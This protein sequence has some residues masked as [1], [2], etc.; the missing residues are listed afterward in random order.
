MIRDFSIKYIHFYHIPIRNEYQLI[1]RIDYSVDFPV[2]S[3]GKASAY[4]VEDPGLIPGLERSPGEG[5]GN[6]LQYSCLENPINWGAWCAALHGV[7]KSLTGLSD[8]TFT[9]IHFHFLS[10][11]LFGYS[12]LN[13]FDVKAMAPHSSTLA[14]QIPWT[15]GPGGL[16]FMG[17]LGVGHDW[18]TSLYFF[19]FMHWRRKWHPLQCSFLENPRDGGTWWAAVYG[20]AQ[21]QTRLKWLSSSR[22]FSILCMRKT[23][24]IDLQLEWTC[25]NSLVAN[26]RSVRLENEMLQG[27]E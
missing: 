14:W 6:P 2:G 23:W 20:V 3:D 22:L 16:Q 19:T 8:F 17:S 25:R 11:S 18:A 12:V 4:N 7:V 21:S 13:C 24:G 10:L 9:F 5:N 27:V 26:W 1:V 15:E